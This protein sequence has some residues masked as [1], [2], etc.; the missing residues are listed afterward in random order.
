MASTT[1]AYMIEAEEALR[2]VIEA[3][4]RLDPE[5]VPLEQAAGLRLAEDIRAD[6]DYPPFDRAMM[7]GYAVRLADAGREVDVIGEVAAGSVVEQSVNNGACLEIMT[8]APCPPGTEAVVQLEH[9]RRSRNGSRVSLPR[10]ISRG[11]HIAPA[12]SECRAGAV[13]MRHGERISELAVAAIASFGVQSVMAYPRPS[14]AVIT[15]GAELVAP[16]TDLMPAQIRDSNGPML[17]ALARAIGIAQLKQLHV[18]D[19]FDAVL[20]A[21]GQVDRTNIVVLTGGVSAGKYDLVPDALEQW[22]AELVFHKVKQKP[23]K[24]LLFAHR[25]R[26]R[27]RQLIFGLPGNPLASHLCFH[28][29]V[30]AAVRAMQGELPEPRDF[31]GVLAEPVKPKG[32]RAYF[33]LGRA[34]PNPD[35]LTQWDIHPVAGTSSADVFTTHQA[36]CYVHVPPTS[37]TLPVGREVPFEWIGGASSW[38]T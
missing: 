21:L 7:D 6:R 29:Y 27:G 20:E 13:V 11:R 24:P 16:D 30:T 5:R 34:R 36:N 8:G 32:G 28:R 12:G 14:V 26:D 23:G 4:P 33:L 17:S 1:A 10:A 31:T 2:L 19:H 35:R 22:G 9:V 3:A 25:D 37:A 38:V 18:R 15:T